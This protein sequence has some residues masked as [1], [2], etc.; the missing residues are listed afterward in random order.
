[1]PPTHPR[2]ATRL[3]LSPFPLQPALNVLGRTVEK[4]SNG[5]FGKNMLVY[6]V[7]VG[8]SAGL[9][10]GATK[11]LFGVPVVYFILAKYGVALLLTYSADE[12]MTNVA[13]DSAGVTTGPVTVPFVLSIGIGFC[14]ASQSAE[15]FGLLTC[16]SVA[17]IITVLLADVARRVYGKAKAGNLLRSSTSASSPTAGSPRAAGSSSSSTGMRPLDLDGGSAGAEVEMVAHKDAPAPTA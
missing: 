6:A 12:A 15:G 10:T 7:C 11:I 4:L 8:V 1:M 5:S 14:K 9:A 13:W 17:P 2:R 16:A 3:P